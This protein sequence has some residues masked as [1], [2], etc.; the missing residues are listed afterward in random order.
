MPPYNRPFVK[1]IIS[2]EKFY[3]K[4]FYYLNKN[5]DKVYTLYNI[6]HYREFNLN[7]RLDKW[8]KVSRVI[9]RRTVANE[10]CDKDKIFVNDKVSKASTSIKVGDKIKIGMGSRVTI[11]EVLKV[12]EGNV[13]TQESKELYNTISQ[14]NE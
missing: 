5:S 6:Y 9:K 7:M 3:R 10:A 1:L 2:L 11:V 12:P 4:N 8:L 14:T 13:S